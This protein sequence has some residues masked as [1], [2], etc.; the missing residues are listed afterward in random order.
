MSAGTIAG[1]PMSRS[2][3][4]ALPEG[5]RAEYVDGTAVMTPG[6]SWEHQAIVQRIYRQLEQMVHPPAAV[7]QGSLWETGHGS[8]RIPDV[9]VAAQRPTGA[10]L[11]EPPLVAVE[12]LSTNRADD[13]VRKSTEYLE[14]GVQQYWVVDPRDHCLSVYRNQAGWKLVLPLD[15]DQ[16]TGLL[17]VPGGDEAPLDLRTILD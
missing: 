17:A 6:P 13:L 4:E 7:S 3:Y 11:T 15:D 8:V 16:P 10:R 5:T 14:A 12:V 1:Q 9:M 2:D